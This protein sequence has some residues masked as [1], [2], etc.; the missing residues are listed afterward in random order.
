MKIHSTVFIDYAFDCI[1]PWNITIG[2]N[3][4][5]GHYNKI[6]AFNTVTLGDYVQ[7]AIGLTIISGSHRSDSYEPINEN[8][9]V[10]LEGENWIGANVTILGGVTIGRGSIIAAGSVVTK[11]IPPYSVAGGVPAKIIKERIASEKVLSP[12]GYYTPFKFK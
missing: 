1:Y 7:T 4:S 3:C 10:V 9:N 11:S 6:W 12:F 5:L 8:M 2:K